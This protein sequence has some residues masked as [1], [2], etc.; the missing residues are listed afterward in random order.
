MA[1]VDYEF[2]RA[3]A[4]DLET[5]A[6]PQAKGA[7][8]KKVGQRWGYCCLGRAEVVAGTKTIVDNNVR[9]IF[10]DAGFHTSQAGVLT[11]N[12]ASRIGL[13][14]PHLRITPALRNKIIDGRSKAY[15]TELN[16]EFKFTFREIAECIRYTWPKAFAEKP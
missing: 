3:W 14:N 10:L 12:T 6:A 4:E 11:S 2:I 9:K 5:T 15:A 7:L 8:C 16:D 1:K 13:D